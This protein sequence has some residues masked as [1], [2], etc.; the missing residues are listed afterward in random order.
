MTWADVLLAGRDVP[1]AYPP[2]VINLI[3]WTAE[4][5]GGSTVD[6]LKLIH[7]V[8]TAVFGPVAYLAW[9]LVLPPL[10][11]LAVTLVAAVPLLEP[12]KPYTTVVLVVLVPV[13][14]R[15]LSE[16]SAAGRASTAG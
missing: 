1:V 12:Y 9:R 10:W 16:L 7:I 8:G 5:T 2:G 14:V 11:A 4:L 13:L 6:A 15:L 3:A